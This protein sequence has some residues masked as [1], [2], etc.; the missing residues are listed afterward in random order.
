MRVL[1]FFKVGLFIAFL[2][3]F[4]ICYPIQGQVYDYSVFSEVHEQNAHKWCQSIEETDVMCAET[5]GGIVIAKKD[6]FPETFSYFNSSRDIFETNVGRADGRIMLILGSDLYK[7]AD[8]AD[9]KNQFYTITIPT[10]SERQDLI[11]ISLIDS[12]KKMNPNIRTEDSEAFVKLVLDRSFGDSDEASMSEGGFL[13]HEL[14]H[15]WLNLYVTEAESKVRPLPPIDAAYGSGLPDWMDE[16][17]AISCEG[18]ADK[19][20]RL[21]QLQRAY[22]SN[23][24]KPL[25]SFLTQRHPY[26]SSNPGNQSASGSENAVTISVQINSSGTVG[27]ATA[28]SAQSY[29]TMKF[30]QFKT[31]NPRILGSI[32]GDVIRG[33]D[34]VSAVLKSIVLTRDRSNLDKVEQLWRTWLSDQF[35]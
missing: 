15:A 30:L 4:S 10:P 32:I 28:Y 14:C 3:M 19:E 12:L 34:P 18:D 31:N 25:S 6:Y 21:V 29:G 13:Q 20:R 24:I 27:E 7:Y 11:K 16:A 9:T 5:R 22:N 23:A 8:Y 2:T 26:R 17:V 1:S 33:S 35:K